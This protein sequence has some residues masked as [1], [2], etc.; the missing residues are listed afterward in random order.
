VREALVS[1]HAKGKKVMLSIGGAAGSSG[2]LAWWSGLGSTSAM[3]AEIERVATAF[4]TAHGVNVDGFDVDIEPKGT[5]VPTR[6]KLRASFARNARCV[7]FS[8]APC[9]LA[10][11]WRSLS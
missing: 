7:T 1:A 5:A 8:R 4:Q 10:R 6:A 9:A 3:T 2:F 11:F